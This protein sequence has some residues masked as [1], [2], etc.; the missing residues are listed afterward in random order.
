MEPAWRAPF[1]H[2]DN[3]EPRHLSSSQLDPNNSKR[4]E[5]LGRHVMNIAFWVP[6][7]D[8]KS[9]S[10]AILELELLSTASWEQGGGAFD[11]PH[12]ILRYYTTVMHGGVRGSPLMPPSLWSRK[13]LACR[14]RPE[15]QRHKNYSKTRTTAKKKLQCHISYSDSPQ[16]YRNKPFPL[17]YGGLFRTALLTGKTTAIRRV[18]FRETI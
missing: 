4:D 9:L 17:L 14:A 8:G 18:A 3:I 10:W 12:L 2:H 6:S 7:T 5:P 11:H 15:L 13:A 1:E 16:R